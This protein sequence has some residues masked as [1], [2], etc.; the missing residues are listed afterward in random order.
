MNWNWSYS[1]ETPNL[2]QH[3]RIFV[4]YYLEIWRWPWKTIGHLF[5]ATSSYLHHSVA[6]G[7]FKLVLQS[8]NAQSG[9]KF[10]FKLCDLNLWPGHFTWTSLL[11]MVIT[12]E[13]FM[14]IRWWEHSEKGMTDRNW[15]KGNLCLLSG[16]LCLLL[17]Q[18]DFLSALG[19]QYQHFHQ[20]YHLKDTKNLEKSM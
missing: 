3:W 12:S 19:L 20:K 18:V 13:I 2:G 6:I 11:A 7:E 16:Y 17:T 5:Y 14:T 1:P 15:V 9:S 4:P 8:G 10:A